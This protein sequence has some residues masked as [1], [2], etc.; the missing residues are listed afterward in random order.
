MA[1]AFPCPELFPL[2]YSG[3]AI[4]WSFA[5]AT[6][7]LSHLLCTYDLIWRRCAG[8]V[9]FDL[10]PLPPHSVLD[11]LTGNNGRTYEAQIRSKVSDEAG[12]FLP[13]KNLSSLML[14]V[15]Y[16]VKE[17]TWPTA[18]QTSTDWNLLPSESHSGQ[19]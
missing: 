9:A 2:N 5:E 17:C 8:Y 16:S 13:L 10:P 1:K 4:I 6:G 11:G 12:T 19:T 18:A 7:T 14:T 15:K 3:A